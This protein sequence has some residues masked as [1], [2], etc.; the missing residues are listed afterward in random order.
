MSERARWAVMPAWMIDNHLAEMDGSMVKVYLYLSRW[1][2]KEGT[3]WHS[4]EKI[5]T[6]CGISRRTVITAVQKLVAMGALKSSKR[7]KTSCIYSLGT[8]GRS[9]KYEGETH[10]TPEQDV[11]PTSQVDVKPTSHPSVKPTSHKVTTDE[12]TTNEETNTYSQPPSPTE[13]DALNLPDWCP[14]GRTWLDYAKMVCESR[15]LDFETTLWNYTNSGYFGGEA[16]N[17]QRFTANWILIEVDCR[18][19][20]K[21]LPGQETLTVDTPESMEAAFELFWDAYPKKEQKMIAAKAFEWAVTQADAALIIKQAKG[22]KRKTDSEK[23]DLQ[24]IPAPHNWLKASRWSD[25][26]PSGFKPINHVGDV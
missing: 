23:T 26:Y 3:L 12:V 1:A 2:N 6:A 11:K 5:A 20:G 17:A 16:P 4:Q 22:F 8:I 7:T 19:K 9:Q 21:P 14:R 25:V 10:F 15:G 24:W 18:T 13:T